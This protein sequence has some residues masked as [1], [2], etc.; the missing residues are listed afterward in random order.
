MP[1]PGVDVA[2]LDT[3]GAVSVESD[4]GTLFATGI[5]ERGPVVPKLLTSL[6][7][8]VTVYGARVTYGIVY[9]SLDEFFREGGARAYIGRVVGPGAT[10]GFLNL[11]DAGAGVS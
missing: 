8:Y 9:D 5:T 2:L 11:L 7:D 4:T 6:N 3:P 10:T 1:R